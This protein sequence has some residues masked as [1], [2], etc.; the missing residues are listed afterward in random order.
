MS[1][2][3]P[4]KLPLPWPAGAGTRFVPQADGHNGP[5]ERE[6][7]RTKMKGGTGKPVARPPI[8]GGLSGKTGHMAIKRVQLHRFSCYSGQTQTSVALNSKCISSKAKDCPDLSTQPKKA[9]ILVYFLLN[10][11]PFI[12]MPSCG[13]PCVS[14]SAFGRRWLTRA[15]LCLHRYAA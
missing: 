6:E 10:I 4:F 1:S 14:F 5:N 12:W 8:G 2:P 15:S 7:Q 9:F 11:G 3:N 13:C